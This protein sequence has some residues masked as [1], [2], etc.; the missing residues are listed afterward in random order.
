MRLPLAVLTALIALAIVEAALRPFGLGQQPVP[1][2]AWLRR[3]PIWGTVNVPGTYVDRPFGG[4]TLTG[5]V[6][7]NADGMRGAPLAATHTRQRI[8]CLGD[9]ST[10]GIRLLDG[11]SGDANAHFRAD[12]AYP[13]QLATLA[14]A[15][16]VNAGVIGHTAPLGLRRLRGLVLPLHPDVVLVRYGFN[17][18]AFPMALI[19]EP[20]PSLARLFYATADLATAKLIAAARAR[21]PAYVALSDYRRALETMADVAAAEGFRL[22]LVDYP[23]RPLGP[24]EQESDAGLAMVLPPLPKLYADHERYAEVTTEVAAARGLTLVR[25]ADVISF[26]PHDRVH[27]DAAGARAIAARVAGVL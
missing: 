12:N 1:G 26:G 16:V 18:H 14:D 6:V 7:I 10:F 17:D 25:T 13:E 24:G 11:H 27:P 23:L 8:V 9:S 22:L 21:A 3:D 5:T 15:E 2:Y 4:G 20:S 19:P